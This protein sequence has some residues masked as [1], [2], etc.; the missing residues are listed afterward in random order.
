[1]NTGVADELETVTSPR[2]GGAEKNIA[3]F[4]VKLVVTGACFWYV[5]KQVDPIQTLE[6][7]N[8]NSPPWAV[9]KENAA[10]AA[11]SAT[12]SE[13]PSASQRIPRSCVGLRA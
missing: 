11:S 9:S 12:A 7:S 10:I 1:M 8:W 2:A 5:F 4:A 13:D 3:I 6:T